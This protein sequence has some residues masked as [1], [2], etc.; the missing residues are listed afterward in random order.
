VLPSLAVLRLKLSTASLQH[1]N[2]FHN[3]LQLPRK[4]ILSSLLPRYPVLPLLTTLPVRA[5]GAK[6]GAVIAERSPIRIRDHKGPAARV[7]QY[8]TRR[9][10]T[11]QD[12]QPMQLGVRPSHQ[13]YS[14]RLVDLVIATRPG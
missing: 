4:I 6:S 7:V 9:V 10:I 2:S 11:V 1:Q 12:A 3:K 14:K 8:I 5:D 13:P